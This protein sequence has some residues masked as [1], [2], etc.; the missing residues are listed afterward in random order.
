MSRRKSMMK[1]CFVL[2]VMIFNICLT[3]RPLKLYHPNTAYINPCIYFKKIEVCCLQN[4]QWFYNKLVVVT[5]VI[6]YIH[7]MTNLRAI[8]NKSKMKQWH[9]IFTIFYTKTYKTWF[10]FTIS[11]ELPKSPAFFTPISIYG[12][13]W[14]HALC[15]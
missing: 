14:K 10:T 2:F 7:F 3:E 8:I 5:K 15:I 9:S 1:K 13:E 6:P 12:I 4:T 11:K